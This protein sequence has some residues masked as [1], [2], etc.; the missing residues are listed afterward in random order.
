[1]D[2][3]DV[4]WGVLSTFINPTIIPEWLLITFF[5]NKNGYT[6]TYGPHHMSDNVVTINASGII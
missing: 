6:L 5:F 4:L 1:M 2:P 3:N